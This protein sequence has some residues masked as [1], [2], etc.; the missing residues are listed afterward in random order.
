MIFVERGG[1]LFAIKGA[2]G[3]FD[4]EKKKVEMI[5][6]WGMCCWL[7]EATLHH[8][9]IQANIY[10]DT[11]F[12]SFIIYIYTHTQQATDNRLP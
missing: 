6:G 5:S 1:G 9:S 12:F 4:Q 8:H 11:P 10:M 2:F 3:V 7:V